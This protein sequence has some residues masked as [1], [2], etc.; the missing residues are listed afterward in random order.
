MPQMK[1][2]QA[3]EF[4][5]FT[6]KKGQVL[7]IF[8]IEGSQ[9]AD[10]CAFSKDDPTEWLSNGRTF[11]YEST[12]FLSIGNKLYSNK[13][14]PMFLISEDKVGRHDFLFAPCSQEMYEIQYSKSEP[15]P[16]CL[17]NLATAFRQLRLGTVQVPTPFNVFMNVKISPEGQL[18][19]QAP[20]SKAGDYV[21]FRAEMDIAVA[22]SACPSSVCN[23]GSQN[24]IGYQIS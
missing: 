4:E 17:D 20:L 12:L 18:E 22:I 21:K 11:D 15:H 9:V 6:L 2:I 14:K 13:S 8:D 19:V 5:A 1:K 7:T 23:G 16:N 3:T 24:P 10:L